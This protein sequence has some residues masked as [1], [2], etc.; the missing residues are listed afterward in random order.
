[1]KIKLV[2]FWHLTSE[3]PGARQLLASVTK[4]VPDW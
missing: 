1:M 4:C 3:Q 2:P